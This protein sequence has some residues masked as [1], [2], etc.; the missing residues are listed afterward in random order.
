MQPSLSVQGEPM[1][2]WPTDSLAIHRR[3]QPVHS[4]QRG[5]LCDN[6]GSFEVADYDQG[7]AQ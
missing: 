2:A 3:H 1:G 4:R 6:R 5:P 7:D